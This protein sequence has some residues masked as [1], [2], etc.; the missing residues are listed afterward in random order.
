MEKPTCPLHYSWQYQNCWNRSA[1]TSNRKLLDQTEAI[2][3]HLLNSASTLDA[4]IVVAS[5]DFSHSWINDL[6]EWMVNKDC[7]ARAFEVF[8]LALQGLDKG[9][10]VAAEHRFANHAIKLLQVDDLGVADSDDEL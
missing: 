9:A 2:C 7:S 5:D 10:A 3:F 4:A 1:S 6:Y 8:A